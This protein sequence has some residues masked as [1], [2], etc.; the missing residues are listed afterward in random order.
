[1]TADNLSEAE[2]PPLSASLSQLRVMG[3][4]LPVRITPLGAHPPLR[5]F[6]QAKTG[7]FLEEL[8]IS[9]W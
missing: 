3:V 4:Q 5:S 8:G 7:V 6:L 9:G 1:M 2:V